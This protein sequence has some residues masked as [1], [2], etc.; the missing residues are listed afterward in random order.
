MAGQIPE[1]DLQAIIDVV[2]GHHDGEYSKG[3]PVHS[4]EETER[5]EVHA[6]VRVRYQRP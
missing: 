6:G 1:K 2:I 4:P 3:D 5:V